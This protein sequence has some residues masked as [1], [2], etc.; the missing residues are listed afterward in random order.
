MAHPRR[1]DPATLLDVSWQIIDEKGFGD[2]TVRALAEKLGVKAASLYRHMSSFDQL[3]LQLAEQAAKQL[4]EQLQ[5]SLDRLADGSPPA[6]IAALAWAFVLWAE[7][8]PGRYDCLAV[9]PSSGP[10]MRG[11]R[12]LISSETRRL[13]HAQASAVPATGGQHAGPETHGAHAMLAFLHGHVMLGRCG[14]GAPYAGADGF[15]E[16]LIALLRGLST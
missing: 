3:K 16:G 7:Q 2:F 8:F 4:G 5:L 6:R 11:L 9:Q 10:A 15:E 1:I 12:S 14:L 13:G